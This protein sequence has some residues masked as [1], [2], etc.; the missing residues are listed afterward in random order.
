MVRNLLV[1]IVLAFVALF[2]TC[3]PAMAAN[4]LMGFDP[5]T[6]YSVAGTHKFIVVNAMDATVLNI[7]TLVFEDCNNTIGTNY[8]I[9]PTT[10]AND[11]AMGIWKADMPA[12][13]PPCS[14]Y[15]VLE[16]TTDHFTYVSPRERWTG[17]AKYF[18]LNDMPTVLANTNAIRGYTTAD[19]IEVDVNT[20][21][22]TAANLTL[23]QADVNAALATSASGIVIQADVNAALAT[24]TNK[25]LRQADVNTALIAQHVVTSGDSNGVNVS[26]IYDVNAMQQIQRAA[27]KGSVISGNPLGT[28][29]RNAVDNDSN[30]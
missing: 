4:E 26:K 15:A 13:T 27:H 10:A 1:T 20:A 30:T 18:D 7:H 22:G 19:A 16:D 21:L 29:Y 8:F 3:R 24:S 17:T 9:T 14:Y 5:N 28:A 11:A 12:S 25:T 2:C 23:R 6:A